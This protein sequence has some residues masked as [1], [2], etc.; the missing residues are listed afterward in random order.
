MYVICSMID[1]DREDRWYH[2]NLFAGRYIYLVISYFFPIKCVVDQ[3]I[4]IVMK[5][6]DVSE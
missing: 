1:A 5:N 4:G 3:G 2:S 6:I